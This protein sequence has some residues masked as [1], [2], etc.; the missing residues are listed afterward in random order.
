[1]YDYF[2]K[3]DALLTAEIK[4]N[5]FKI[6]ELWQKLSIENNSGLK[7]F[8]LQAPNDLNLAQLDVELKKLR[9][10]KNQLAEALQTEY[11]ECVQIKMQFIPIITNKV[12]VE[13]HLFPQL[14]YL[15]EQRLPLTTTH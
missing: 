6:K 13:Q 8:I 2:Q 11:E 7:H 15:W 4:S 3:K 10:T 12:E 14:D 5:R 9:K 1:V